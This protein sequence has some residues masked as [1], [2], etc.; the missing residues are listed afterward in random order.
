MDIEDIAPVSGQANAE[1]A[2]ERLRIRAILT[3]EQGKANPELANLLALDHGLDAATANSILA[4][5]AETKIS[6]YFYAAMAK[7]GPVGIESNAPNFTEGD[8]RAVRLAEINASVDRFN[9][10]QRV[11]W[12]RPTGIGAD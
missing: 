8:A 10:V 7:E 2:Q 6:P 11:G 5:A 3:S 12:K 9:A 4:K 1:F